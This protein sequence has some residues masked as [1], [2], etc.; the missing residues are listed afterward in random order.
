MS[1]LGSAA[2]VVLA[3]VSVLW[4][5]LLILVMLELRHVS[6]RLQEF[7]RSLEM[8]LKPAILEAR[9]AVRNLGQVARGVSDATARLQRPLTALEEAGEN[10]RVTTGVLRSV[11]GSRMIPVASLIAGLRAG[12]KALW[13]MQKGRHKGGK[14]HE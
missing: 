2:L 6:W 14:D 11:F 4:T 1:N 8:E 13:H 5:L 3:A 9:E 12:A 10:I 7:I